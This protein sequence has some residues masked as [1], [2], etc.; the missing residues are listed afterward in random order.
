[1]TPRIL[2]WDLENTP[3]LGYFW[4]Q[5]WKT[6][7]L[8]VVEPSRV[9]SFAA[10]WTDEPNS[11]IEFRSTHHD[12]RQV[13]LQRIRTL[14]DEAD[15]AVTWNGVRHDT[16]HISTEFL[17]EGLAPPSPYREVDLM[18]V[19]KGKLKFHNNRLQYVSEELELGSKVHHEGFSLWLKCMAGDDRAWAAMRRYNIGDVVVLKRNYLRLKPLIPQS[20]H[21]NF[22][23]Y[24][25]GDRC[26]IC[27]STKLQRRG[28]SDTSVTRFPRYQC[29]SCGKWSQGKFAVARADMRGAA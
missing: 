21:P 22:N 14:L 10:G 5:T 2:L 1:M 20:M 7:I 19:A 16:P 27:G 25:D 9:M 15:A 13:M 26:P 8:K 24:C 18:K 29:R 23:L 12:G 28:Y 4:G 6:D 11:K 17:R 3:G